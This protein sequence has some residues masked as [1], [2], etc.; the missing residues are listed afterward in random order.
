MPIFKPA[1]LVPKRF[2]GVPTPIDHYNL[3]VYSASTIAPYEL[4]IDITSKTI[5]VNFS[6]DVVSFTTGGTS[7]ASTQDLQSVLT[8][9]NTADDLNIILNGITSG[10]GLFGGIGNMF[11][12]SNGSSM[13][14]GQLNIL[15]GS[16][17]SSV[18]VGGYLNHLLDS[19]ASSIY[20]GQQNII[21]D[22]QSAGVFA[23]QDN[24]IKSS[25]NL[26][27]ILGG[28]ENDIH[29]SEYGAAV[30][31]WNNS[32]SGSYYSTLIASTDCVMSGVTGSAVIG[33]SGLTA[34]RDF[35]TYVNQIEVADC[36]RLKPLSSPPSDPPNG[37][38]Y[39][40]NP[41]GLMIYHDGTW[42]TIALI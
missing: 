38:I 20:G 5:V 17:Q 10:G 12:L 32:M 21:R 41:K 30:G 29:S 19:F 35:T 25:S 37:T 39:Y 2:D 40:N 15:S 13:L 8:E 31:A 7:S 22:S 9:G 23:G 33:C 24:T 34:T 1:R 3:A 4:A 26:S 42:N 14:G 27:A 28:G 16:S 11:D 6:G 36:I 18:M